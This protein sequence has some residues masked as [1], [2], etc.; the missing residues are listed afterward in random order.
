MTQCDG[1]SGPGSE[2]GSLQIH[3]MDVDTWYY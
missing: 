1:M 3:G 2:P